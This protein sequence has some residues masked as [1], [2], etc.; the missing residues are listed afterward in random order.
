MLPWVPF[1][2]SNGI[3]KTVKSGLNPFYDHVHRSL[4]SSQISNPNSQW[5]LWFGFSEEYLRDTEIPFY[6]HL[7][8]ILLSNGMVFLIMSILRKEGQF[9]S[10][11]KRYLLALFLVLALNFLLGSP[12]MQSVHG[13]FLLLALLQALLFTD[14]VGVVAVLSFNGLMLA[15][16]MNNS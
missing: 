7:A 11:H 3:A 14:A 5:A 12:K 6:F 2:Y 4:Y 10:A 9:R 1:I 15:N 16:Q 8:F 13:S